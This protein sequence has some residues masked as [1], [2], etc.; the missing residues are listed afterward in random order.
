MPESIDYLDVAV[1]LATKAHQGQL[2]KFGEPFISHA[3]AVMALVH[4][5]QQRI[6]AVFHDTVEA[7]WVTLDD[8]SRRGFGHEVIEAVDALTMRPGE[9]LEQYLGRIVREESGDA[10]VVKR[11]ALASNA[12]RVRSVDELTGRRLMKQYQRIA[13]LLGT[14]V[15]DIL[16][17]H[18]APGRP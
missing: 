6:I 14:T 5:S 7:T 11:A 13:A 16:A 17:A 8:I 18:W 3:L 1:A 15:D 2:D 12:G 10:L 9:T 4:T